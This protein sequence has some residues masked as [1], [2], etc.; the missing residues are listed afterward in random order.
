M[1]MKAF[2]Y[3]SAKKGYNQK[4]TRDSGRGRNKR[5]IKRMI[6]LQRI[7][8]LAAAGLALLLAGCAAMPSVE[9]VKENESVITSMEKEPNLSYEVP[10]SSPN[11]LVNQLGYIRSGTKIAIFCGEEKPPEFYVIEEST[12]ERV[13][14]GRPED[15]AAGNENG[16]QFFYGDFSEVMTEGTYYLEAPLIGKS[17]SFLIEEDLYDQVFRE[18]CR[19]YY[20][21]RCGVTLTADYA[22]EMAHNACHTSNSVLQEDSSVSIDARGGWHQDEAGSKDVMTAAKSIGVMLLAYELYG[23][24]FGDDM[25]IPESENGVPDILDEVK[26]EIEWLLKMQ[27]PATGA[28]YKGVT[29]YDQSVGSGTVS[30]VESGDMGTASA[31]AMALAKFSYLYQ[32]YDTAYATDCLKA[33]DRAWKYTE[34]NGGREHDADPWKFAAAA[35]L[36]RAS[37]LKSCQRFVT[38]YLGQED[39]RKELDEVTFLGYVAYISTKLPVKIELCEKIAEKLMEKAEEI[40]EEARNSDY[41][42]KEGSGNE[43]NHELLQNMMY[44]TM[45]DYMIAN[46]EYESLIE[47]HLHYFLGR[48]PQAI[49]YINNIGIGNGRP[50]DDG[51][52]I[53]KQFEADSK[54]IFMLSE[55]VE[56]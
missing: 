54:L 8:R 15:N 2:L 30:Y 22:G 39:E 16:K 27:D 35:E 3:L 32:E 17:Y 48:N 51:M 10:E 4:E 42:V 45:V 40:S 28:V 13:F 37:G 5:S 12:G 36:Y 50:S 23:A 20:Y 9:E 18:A 29:V 46:H 53:M 7:R 49:C 1:R 56:K 24:S 34:L 55:I 14:V 19:Q 52:G 21:N 31:F 41:L 38:E 43:H 47:N 6:V 25:G 44:L 26:Y 33:A 11:I